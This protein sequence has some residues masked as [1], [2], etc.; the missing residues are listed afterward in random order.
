MR[1]GTFRH[2]SSIWGVLIAALLLLFVSGLPTFAAEVFDDGDVPCAMDCEGSNGDERCPPNCPY[3]A[4]AKV[5]QAVPS[6]PSVPVR[7]IFE[8]PER[9]R[10]VLDEVVPRDSVDEVFHPPRV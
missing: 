10:I 9:V 8:S 3:G 7:T 4:C 2:R 1:H 5:F 6:V